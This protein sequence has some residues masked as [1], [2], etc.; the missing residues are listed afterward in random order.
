MGIS[1]VTRN[2]QVTLPKDVRELSGIKEGDQ[3]I[4]NVDDEGR[5]IISPLRRSPVDDSFGIWEGE[6]EGVRYTD[7]IRGEWGARVDE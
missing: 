4:V 3:V 7:I 5:I 1:V 6:I 2:S